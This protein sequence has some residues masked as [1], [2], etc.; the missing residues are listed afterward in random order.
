MSS[1]TGKKRISSGG[2]STKKYGKLIVFDIDET[3]FTS[4]DKDKYKDYVKL[5]VY[6]DKKPDH[7]VQHGNEIQYMFSRPYLKQFMEFC[8][9]HFDYIGFYTMADGMWLRKFLDNLI[10]PEMQKHS[11]FL[12]DYTDSEPYKGDR[13]DRIK[14]LR[15]IWSRFGHLGI[16]KSNTLFIEDTFENLREDPKNCI[17]VPEYD[18]FKNAKDI[19]L[20]LL[21]SYIMTLDPSK[22]LPDQVKSKGWFNIQVKRLKSKDI[23][24]KPWLK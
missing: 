18:V 8:L 1:S 11:L 7:R 6:K 20:P 3:L 9:N 12:Y 23:D 22:P 2:K 13:E 19:T 16:D 24:I 21:A 4:I 17:V 10:G 15:K 5:S 14:S